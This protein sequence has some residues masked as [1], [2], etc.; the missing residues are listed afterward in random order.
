MYLHLTLEPQGFE[1]WGSTYMWIF[2]SKCSL[3]SVYQQVPHLQPNSG[4]K[5]SIWG[6][7]NPRIGRANFLYPQGWLQ[8]LSSIIVQIW[9]VGVSWNQFPADTKRRLYWLF[10]IS[11]LWIGWSVPFLNCFPYCFLWA[12]FLYLK[13]NYNVASALIKIGTK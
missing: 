13:Y 3:S 4:W 9:Y 12:S 1:L 2:F 8:G 7:Q 5:Y 10:S 11:F 6:M